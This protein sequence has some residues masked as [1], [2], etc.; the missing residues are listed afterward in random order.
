M[1]LTE[2]ESAFAKFFRNDAWALKLCYLSDIFGKLN[3]LNI[4][5]LM[6]KL[7]LLLKSLQYG[8]IAQKMAIWKCLLLQ[9]I[10]YLTITCPIS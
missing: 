1:F 5:L 4:S 6:I 9:M 7:K 8:K 2:Q 10:I 3:D